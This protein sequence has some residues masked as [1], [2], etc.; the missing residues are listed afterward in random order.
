[1]IKCITKNSGGSIMSKTP[2]PVKPTDP[3]KNT[4]TILGPM[5]DQATVQMDLQNEKCYWNSDAFSQGDQISVDGKYY[6]CSYGR[7]VEVDD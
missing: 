5:S 7:W 2:T 1:M 4:S 3:D 6:E